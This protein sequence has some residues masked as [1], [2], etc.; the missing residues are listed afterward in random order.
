MKIEI[1]NIHSACGKSVT[2]DVDS[3]QEVNLSEVYNGI[4]IETEQGVFGFAQKDGGIEIVLNGEQIWNS[5]EHFFK[6]VRDGH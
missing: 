4:G 2:I 5:T 6:K 1:Y 3:T